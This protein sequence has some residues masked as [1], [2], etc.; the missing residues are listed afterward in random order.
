V[1]CQELVRRVCV[2]C[3]SK[4]VSALSLLYQTIEHDA[5]QNPHFRLL[6]KRS[7]SLL[8]S[9]HDINC[10]KK[11]VSSLDPNIMRTL[12][13]GILSLDK[14]LRGGFRIGTVSEVVGRAGVGKT[15]LALQL[16]VMAA[17]YGQGSIY[18][19][20]E[21]KLSIQ[22]LQEIANKRQVAF[23]YEGISNTPSRGLVFTHEEQEHESNKHNFARKQHQQQQ[24]AL[25]GCYKSSQQVLQSVTVHTPLTCA[26]L[27]S[28]IST[29]DEEILERNENASCRII[30]SVSKKEENSVS[31]LCSFPVRL[32]ILDSIA[33]PTRRDFGQM[34][35]APQRASAVFHIAQMLKRLA[36]QTNVAVVV[37]N[38]VGQQSQFRQKQS[39]EQM[40]KGEGN[41]R[42]DYVA[43]NAALGTSWHHCVTTRLLLEHGHDLQC[44]NRNYTINDAAAVKPIIFEKNYHKGSD[45][46][47]A[48]KSR[49]AHV[50][51]GTLVKSNVSGPANVFLEMTSMGMNEFR[52]V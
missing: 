18:I 41:N 46:A 36:D 38:Q 26:E 11:N 37:I 28:V 30:P 52:N 4:P 47:E 45:S 23:G 3:S 39:N 51:R 50:R 5:Y 12:P 49:L 34:E 42:S 14:M 17:R 32:V 31:S 9:N 33:A 8:L 35:S 48:A 22:R 16:C 19:D 1:E 43:I 20:T 24:E 7:K 27:I 21:R 40:P 13:T 44:Y 25:P 2:A 10:D 6:R 29:L 15:Q